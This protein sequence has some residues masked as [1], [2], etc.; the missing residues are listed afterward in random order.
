MSWRFELL[1]PQKYLDSDVVMREK[2]PWDN[3]T[4]SRFGVLEEWA[5]TLCKVQSTLKPKVDSMS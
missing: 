3:R 5:A 4:A 2:K 1:D